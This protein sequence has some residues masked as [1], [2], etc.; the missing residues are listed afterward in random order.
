MFVPEKKGGLKL[1]YCFNCD[2]G[3]ENQGSYYYTIVAF[4]FLGYK[5]K[6]LFKT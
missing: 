4:S 6:H 2:F 1:M 5:R 3:F